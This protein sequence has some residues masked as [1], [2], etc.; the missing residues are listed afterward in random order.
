VGERSRDTESS[1][2][3]K[4]ILKKRGIINTSSIKKNKNNVTGSPISGIPFLFLNRL[5]FDSDPEEGIET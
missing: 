3:I 5:L 1:S 2:Q 4:Y